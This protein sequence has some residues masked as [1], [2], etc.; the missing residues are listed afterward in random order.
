MY[1]GHKDNKKTVQHE[2][3]TDQQFLSCLTRSI[4]LVCV[5]SCKFKD[6]FGAV[7]SFIVGPVSLDGC[8]VTTVGAKAGGRQQHNQN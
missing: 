4:W 5:G 8:Y 7:D 6:V 2:N 1:W 3:P